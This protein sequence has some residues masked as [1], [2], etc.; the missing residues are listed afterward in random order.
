MDSDLSLGLRIVLI[1]VSVLVLLY[2]L[3]KIRQSKLNITDS[4]FWIVVAALLIILS[5]F[6]QIAYALSALIGIQTP[7]NF[8]LLLMIAILILKVFLMTI[9]ISQLEEKTKKLA[10]KI[11]YDEFEQQVEKKD[12][13]E[14]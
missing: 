8:I 13:G 9:K 6:P 1:I 7:L 5:V 3:R 2:V 10:Q 4:I 14:K 12:G 11:A